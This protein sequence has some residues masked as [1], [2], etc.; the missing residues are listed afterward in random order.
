[1]EWLKDVATAFGILLSLV[2]LLIF[3]GIIWSGYTFEKQDR[4]NE[5][6]IGAA[7]DEIRK[8]GGRV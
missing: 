7:D 6:N 3:I 2:A 4:E 1:M 5:Y 8:A